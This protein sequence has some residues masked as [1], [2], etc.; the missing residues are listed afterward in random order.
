M[1]SLGSGIRCQACGP[2]INN[3]RY[4]FACDS[5]DD[6]G[7]SIDHHEQKRI[8][9]KCVT[10]MPIGKAMIDELIVVKLDHFS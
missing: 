9:A 2:N 6:N 3:G 4:Y 10:N 7:K 5:D 8:L 1:K